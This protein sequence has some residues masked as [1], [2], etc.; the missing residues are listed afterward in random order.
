MT[1]W[2][3]QF[4]EWLDDFE[5]AF[6]E[7]YFLILQKIAFH[8]KIDFGVGIQKNWFLFETHFFKKNANWQ[9]EPI[10][11]KFFCAKRQFDIVPYLQ[12][13]ASDILAGDMKSNVYVL[14]RNKLKCI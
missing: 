11:F 2:K 6:S 12:Q 1:F 10:K 5:K 7:V 3:L 8:T 4:T 13:S 14:L 9:R